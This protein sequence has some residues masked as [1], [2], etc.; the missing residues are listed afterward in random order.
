[1]VK[2]WRKVEMDTVRYFDGLCHVKQLA[3]FYRTLV[4]SEDVSKGATIFGEDPLIFVNDKT[5]SK[6]GYSSRIFALTDL[7]LKNMV[8]LQCLLKDHDIGGKFSF[9]QPTQ[10][11]L[12][13]GRH[14]VAQ[15]I[16]HKDP[17]KIFLLLVRTNLNYLEKDGTCSS[18]YYERLAFINHNC[19][20]SCTV[21]QQEEEGKDNKRIILKALRDIRK[22]EELTISY[23]K[24]IEDAPYVIRKKYLLETYAFECNCKKCELEKNFISK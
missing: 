11:E 7:V 12:L 2:K 23:I 15:H 18:G 20:P 1:M 3:P 14:L 19:N 6:M 9:L 22:G 5:V 21:L 17:I 24:G 4:V 8:V 13:D 16:A 10:D